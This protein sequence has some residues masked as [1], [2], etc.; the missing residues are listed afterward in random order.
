MITTKEIHNIFIIDNE[1]FEIVKDF[2]YLGLVIS[3][4][5]DRSQ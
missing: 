5:E 3:L 4:N 1:D 2:T